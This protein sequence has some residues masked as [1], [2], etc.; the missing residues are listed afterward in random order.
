MYMV[1]VCFYVC[2]RDCGGGVSGK[3]CCVAA[4]FEKSVFLALECLCKPYIVGDVMD[5]VFS[6]Y[7]VRR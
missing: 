6:V 3:V 5:V 4:V 1:H 2:C 7:I